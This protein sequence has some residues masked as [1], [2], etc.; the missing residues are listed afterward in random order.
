MEA[1]GI[2]ADQALKPRTSEVIAD[3]ISKYG[4]IALL[5]AFPAYYGIQDLINDGNLTRIGN[6]LVDGLSNGAI[7]ALVALGSRSST[8]SSSSSTSPTARS[9]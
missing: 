9:S 8:G 7:W 3:F 6:N 5:I 4:L 1:A 2:S